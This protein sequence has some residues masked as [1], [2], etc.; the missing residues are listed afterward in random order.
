MDFLLFWLIVGACT[1][2]YD[3]AFLIALFAAVMFSK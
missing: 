2:H 3:S 1:G